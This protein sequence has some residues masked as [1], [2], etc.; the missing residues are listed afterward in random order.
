M[1]TL[2]TGDIMG[3][4]ILV[5]SDCRMTAVDPVESGRPLASGEAL[6]DT[7]TCRVTFVELLFPA[8]VHKSVVQV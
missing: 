7:N 2:K 4:K 5:D 6:G 3:Q 8:G 1:I